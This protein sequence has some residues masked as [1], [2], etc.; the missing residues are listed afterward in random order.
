GAHVDDGDDEV[1]GGG[2]GADTADEQA[3]HVEVD[4]QAGVVRQRGEGRVR[5]PADVGGAAQEDARVDHQPAERVDPVAERV[6]AGEGQVTGADLQRHEVVRQ[7][8]AQRHDGQEHHG[9]AVHG[10]ELVELVGVHDPHV[11][12]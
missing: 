5:H 12:R 8:D 4:A 1:H 10:E 3:E 9:D 6:Q 2:G 7:P 11:G